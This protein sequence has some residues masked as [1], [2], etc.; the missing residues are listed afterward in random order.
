MAMVLVTMM[1]DGDGDSSDDGD[2][3]GDGTF[4]WISAKEI[5]QLGLCA[6]I[7]RL[8]ISAVHGD[9]P[10]TNHHHFDHVTIT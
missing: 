3:N 8:D 1:M 10:V 2:R 5:Q 4:R 9:I 7:K 6:Q